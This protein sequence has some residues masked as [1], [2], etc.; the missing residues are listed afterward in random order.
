LGVLAPERL[1]RHDILDPQTVARILRDHFDGRETNDALIW[2][3]VVFQTWF[4]LYVDGVPS[5]VGCA[6]PAA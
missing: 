3:L 4:D 1:A 2:S 5:A 6:A